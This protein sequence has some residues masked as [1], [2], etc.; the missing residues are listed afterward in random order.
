MKTL[1]SLAIVLILAALAAIACQ[2][3]PMVDALPGAPAADTPMV[4]A[5]PG[6]PAA[7]TTEPP[8]SLSEVKSDIKAALDTTNPHKRL[9]HDGT[10]YRFQGAI[11]HIAPLAVHFDGGDYT[12]TCDSQSEKELR[13]RDDQSFFTLEVETPKPSSRWVSQVIEFEAGD[14]VVAEGKYY[15]R[16]SNTRDGDFYVLSGCHIIERFVPPLRKHSGAAPVS[17]DALEAV[18]N[19]ELKDAVPL[20]EGNGAPIVIPVTP[21]APISIPIPP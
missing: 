10:P 9:L 2:R 17:I 20:P 5:L 4:E 16:Y 3:A 21:G 7:D 13:R 8:S 15:K 19:P 18:P 6:T 11:K 14:V 12:L 1:L